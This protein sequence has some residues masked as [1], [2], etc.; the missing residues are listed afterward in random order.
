MLRVMLNK[1]SYQLAPREFAHLI[2]P[3]TPIK[4]TV[5]QN[6]PLPDTHQELLRSRMLVAHSCLTFCDPMD[7]SP[8]GSSLRGILQA[9]ILKWVAI[10]FPRGSS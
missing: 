1:T 8:P 3:T 7:C 9:G 10:S 6:K 2:L 4:M 5:D